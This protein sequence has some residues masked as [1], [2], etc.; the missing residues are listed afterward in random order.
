[1]KKKSIAVAVTAACIT[2]S[3]T[4]GGCS[5]VTKNNTAD[6]AQEIA[7]VD[8]RK[9]EKF[10]SS[11]LKDYEGAIA[12]SSVLKRDLLTAFLNVG[13]SYMNDNSDTSYADVFNMLVNSLVNNEILTQYAIM[14]CLEDKSTNTE[15]ILGYASDALSKFNA[16][17]DDLQGKYEYLLGGEN[18]DN[19]QIK[20]AKYRWYSS[21][22]SAIDN[23]EETADEEEGYKGTETRTTPV[24]LDT[25]Q[26]D[27]F[28]KDGDGNL[29]YNVYTGYKGYLLS[30]SG[31][32]K[33]DA[34]E[35]TNADS[36][37][38][39]YN[40]FLN[41]LRRNDFI[42]EKESQNLT[43]IKSL[44]YIKN[45]YVSQLESSIVNVFYDIY[46]EKQAAELSKN[47]YAY[48]NDIYEGLVDGQKD[49][50][51]TASAFES[52]MSSMSSTSFILSSPDTSDS[53]KLYGTEY[54]GKFGFVYNILLPFDS[55][56][57]VKLAELNSI[58][59]LDEDE[60]YYYAERN[61]LLRDI[62]T[63]DQ[64]GA[65]FNGQTDYSF[66]ASESGITEYYG[67]IKGYPAGV[68]NFDK[69]NTTGIQY[70]DDLEL[71]VEYEVRF[72]KEVLGLTVG[73][74]FTEVPKYAADY[75]INLIAE[76]SLIHTID[77]ETLALKHNY[78]IVNTPQTEYTISSRQVQVKLNYSSKEYVYGQ[79][80]E[81]PTFTLTVSKGQYED[82]LP[83]DFSTT[84]LPY[85]ETCD[86][87]VEYKGG[88]NITAEPR[89]VGKYHYEIVK[90][91][92][93]GSEKLTGNYWFSYQGPIITIVP[94]QIEI[95][96]DDMSAVYGDF[97]KGVP[98]T[99]TYTPTEGVLEYTDALT[100]NI[101]FFQTDE[102]GTIKFVTPKNADS[103]SIF[104]NSFTV[105]YFDGA[106]ETAAGDALKNYV[107]TCNNGTLE[108][109]KKQL[110]IAI[111]KD[112]SITY[113]ESAPDYNNIPYTLSSDGKVLTELPYGDKVNVAMHY[114]PS[115]PVNAGTYKI[116]Y[117][118]AADDYLQALTNY[119]VHGE[120]GLLTV[121]PKE[122]EATVKGGTAVYGYET[123]PEIVPVIT[124]GE[125]VGNEKLVPA[126]VFSLN[127]TVCDP[128]NVGT[129]DISVDETRCAVTGG[130]GL[131]GN[132][133]VT[134]IIDGNL[135]I[136]AS[137]LTVQI[138]GDSFTYGERDINVT[139]KVTA[140]KLYHNDNLELTYTYINKESGDRSENPTAA[141]S[142]A[143]TATATITGGN[144]SVDNYAITYV[145]DDPTLTITKR[146]I[147]ITL[148]QGGVTAFT[149]GT[150]YS[151][152]ICNAQIVGAVDGQTVTVAVT[153]RKKEE[154]GASAFSMLRARSF[155]ARAEAF[156]PKDAGTYIA[157]LDWDSCAVTDADGNAVDGGID[158]YELK[159]ACAD[160]EFVIAPMPLT[161]T[162]ENA[163]VTYGDKLPAALDYYVAENMPYG[164]SLALTFS[165][166]QENGKLPVH[167]GD[168]PVKVSGAAVNAG[169]IDN[170]VPE[171][172]NKNPRL[173]I[174]RRSLDI[175]LNS[176]TRSYGA[177]VS[178]KV[179][180]NNYVAD[181]SE[182]LVEGDV[183]TSTEVS[184]RGEDGTVYEGANLP[185]NVGTYAIVYVSSSITNAEGEDASADYKVNGIDGELKIDSSVITVYTAS[186]EETYNG[187]A[188][189][190]DKYD[191]YDGDLRGYKLVADADNICKQIDATTGDGVD[192]TTKFKIVDESGK[193]TQNLKLQYGEYGKLKVNRKKVDVTIKEATADYGVL[194]AIEHT[195]IG[196]VAE[197]MLSFSV[198]YAQGGEKVT[199]L[200]VGGFFILPVG[201]YVMNYVEDSA[202]ITGGQGKATN[203]ELV[204]A[205]DA[206]F[207]VTRRHIAVTTAGDGREYNGSP[208]SKTDGYT[209]EWVVDGVRQTDI[210]GLI[211]GDEL[212][213]A[214]TATQ[215]IVGSSS[216]ACTYTVSDNY[217]IDEELYEY[218]TLTVTQ[219]TVTAKTADVNVIYDGEPH[220]GGVVTDS[221][222]KLVAGHEF[223]VTSGLVAVVDVTAGVEN[224]LT[225]KIV[226]TNDGDRDV[227]ANYSVNYAYGKIIIRQRPLK[228]TTGGV[229]GVTYDGK[230]HGNNNYDAAEGLLTDEKYGHTLKVDTEF[231]Y[232][233]ATAGVENKTTYKVYCNG[234]DIS[235]NYAVDY[236][237]GSI[238]ID[239]K[240]VTVTLNGGVE[241][242]Y[243][244]GYAQLLTDGAV[245]LIDGE[246]IELAIK[247]DR[248]VDGVGVYTATADWQ[249][250][251]VRN[252]QGVIENGANNYAP[253]FS[254]ASVQFSVI[255]REIVVTLNAGC[256]TQFAYG[257]N[258]DTAIRTVTVSGMVGGETLNAAVTYNV[259]NPKYVGSYTAYIDEAKCTVNGG[260]I[261][262]YDIVACN[263]VNFEIVAKDITVYTDDINI[264]YGE[265]PAYPEGA[266]GYK[267]VEGLVGGDTLTV[268]PAFR[269][270]GEEVTSFVAG[271]YDIICGGITVNGG[272]VGAENYNFTTGTPY[273][274]LTVS[275]IGVEIVRK[276]VTKPYDGTPL[277]L[278]ANAPE[279]EVS[280]IING[281]SGEKLPAGYHIELVGTFATR[282][283]NVSS[284]CANT[285]EY[286]VVDEAT[287]EAAGNYVVTYANNGA[288]LEIVKKAIEITTDTPE[289]RA[290][291][292]QPLTAGYTF[293]ET[294]L[295]EGH[296]LSASNRASQKD[297]G[298]TANTMTFT[299]T[300]NGADVTANY[301]INATY[302][303]L[304][305]NKLAVSVEI[306]SVTKAYG[307]N[308]GV[309][310][311]NRKN[312]VNDEILYYRLQLEKD[313]EPCDTSKPLSAGTYEIV[314]KEGDASVSGG[315]ITNY[316]ISFSDGSTLKV[317][318]RQIIIYTANAEAEYSGQPLSR[319]DGYTTKWIK[320]DVEQNES[321]LINGD[322]LTVVTFASQTEVGSRKNECTYVLSD[323]AGNYEIAG[324]ECGTLTVTKIALK[325]TTNDINGVYKGSPYS[326]GGFTYDDKLLDGHTIAL[327]GSVR[328]F[329]DVIS[330]AKNEFKVAITA[331]GEDVTEKYYEIS[332]TYGD[333]NITKA[334]LTL[335]PND[336]HRT[337][338]YGFGNFDAQF[339][340]VAADNL[341]GND[342]LTTVALVYI[343]EDGSVLDGEPVN[344]GKYKVKVNLAGS[345]ISSADGVNRTD[346]YAV[347]CEEVTF[348]V[349]RRKITVSLNSWA[350]ETYNG[351]THTYAG[352]CEI[353]DGT[354]LGGETITS[355]V[356]AYYTDAEKN[357]SVAAPKDADTYYVFPDVSASKVRGANGEFA[358][359]QNYEVTCSHIEFT[360]NPK[361]L[362]I[363]LEDV[364][365]TYDG[366][367]YDYAGCGGMT[368]NLCD[369]DE[370]QCN[371]TYSGNHRDAGAYTVTFNENLVFTSG[372]A[373][374]YVLDK[375]NSKLTCELTISERT[376]IVWVDD[377]DV[378]KGSGEYTYAHITSSSAGDEG[379]VGNDLENAELTFRYFDESNTELEGM[380]ATVGTYTVTA[381]FG[382]DV[383]KNYVVQ[384]INAGTLKVTERKVRVT[385]VFNGTRPYYYDGNPVDGG[386]FGFVH[387]HSPEGAPTEEAGF[388][389]DD[390][391]NI[392]AVYTFTDLSNGREYIGTTPANAGM[393]RIS[394]KLTTLSGGDIEGYEITYR[395][396]YFTIEKRPLSYTVKVTGA[397]EY[398]YS[399]SRP[400]FSAELADGYD[401]FINDN[402]LPEHTFE[403]FAGDKPVTRYNV[404]TYQVRMAFEGME[405]YAIA[406]TTATVKIVP[407][408][409]VITPV[410]PYNG[411]AQPYNGTGLRLGANDREIVSKVNENG[412]LAAGDELTIRSTVFNPGAYT[413]KGRLEIAEVFIT[414]G[415]ADVSG[416]YKYYYQYDATNEAIKS[417]NLLAKDFR[418]D[419][420]YQQSVIH[421]EFGDLGQ[422]VYPY[423]GAAVPKHLDADTVKLADGNS[424]KFG[425]VLGL[426]KYDV[427]VPAAA[428]DYPD[429]I[430]DLV[431]V[432]DASGNNVSAIYILTCDNPEAGEIKVTRNVLDVQ[433][434]GMTADSL[435]AG[436]L[437][438]EVSGLFTGTTPAHQAEVYAFNLD[439]S[440][441]VGVT[442][443]SESDAGK[444]TD[445][446][447]NYELDGNCKL[448]G[449]TVRI[450]TLDEEEL[451]KRPSIGVEITVTES[452]LAGGKGT[453]YEFDGESRW[454]LK[455]G[456]TV[457]GVD[458]LEKNGHKLQV[459]VFREGGKYLLGV[460]VYSET[461]G[462]RSDARS[463]YRL[464]DLIT[465][466]V[467]ARYIAS[468][469]AANMQ[470]EIY[471]DFSE[472]FN[473]D[474]T[475]KTENGLLTGYS[476]KGLSDGHKIEVTVTEKDGKYEIG[477]AIFTVNASGRKLNKNTVYELKAVVP[478][479]VTAGII[480]GNL[481]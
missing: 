234:N 95:T 108:I 230:P 112:V 65:W 81:K 171:Y 78:N 201:N 461:N 411:V 281:D 468:S 56:Q 110:T 267:R 122:I 310:S 354:L 398:V 235:A 270:N 308:Y 408:T 97:E 465:S 186:L 339:K 70:S 241:V 272:A 164:E 144:A 374:N 329:T 268:I 31:A 117:E 38:K 167:V 115:Q 248:A 314:C 344:A 351:K 49:V 57:S 155:A 434:N 85:G 217:V 295:I 64:R 363:E 87:D 394:V 397:G 224:K 19:N 67:N 382:G 113:G 256:K 146:G 349:A 473:A 396:G 302:G 306:E 445:L 412:D 195:A 209:T 68:G 300:A 17:G 475:P 34:K 145:D 197:E 198:D 172:T 96:L 299:I 23:Y 105:T 378:E 246:T 228:I 174:T 200:T 469:E 423:T 136:T 208:L 181:A 303:T 446:S 326:D 54:S 190:T 135:E 478:D 205:P 279:S 193:E 315:N 83:A 247:V 422:T 350:D 448:D 18:N 242:Q 334:A 366:A 6:L 376:I 226:D 454:I 416:N 401:G 323:N 287:G 192:N 121:K 269:K 69:A 365:H 227:T 111:S 88:L 119:D 10:A 298:S 180:A 128:V 347:T 285:A 447:A 442:V 324:Y 379:F 51:T 278:N 72:A 477:V 387:V 221:L 427:N 368:T 202:Q 410:D 166:E 444:R 8:I 220:S 157:S 355:F 225:V 318:P 463:T 357:N 415:G 46:E 392:K 390:L 35:G 219:R 311:I 185:E 458:A 273:G 420:S 342:S 203:Y 48:I 451:Y 380:P 346:N 236:K 215:T 294:Q 317:T 340:P 62:R 20:L 464:K 240:A 253:E 98:A 367:V 290:Y 91:Y 79:K 127:G 320:D 150:P 466:G 280:Y 162:V 304:T 332:Y 471:I 288:R 159:A 163:A 58:K 55:K 116:V 371:I 66:K 147:E 2:L 92:V 435:T 107:I 407:R 139:F 133:K 364:S 282:D 137:P 424:L 149:Y 297:V 243:G 106:E 441:L 199:P 125:M 120:D 90:S 21:L 286:R 265:T 28:P 216:N 36:R 101:G 381:A 37:K 276:T 222:F 43:D 438:L 307:E 385:P 1:M 292:G 418:V 421:Y 480:D 370:I 187:A 369:G 33:D 419:V 32:Y 470:R 252:A 153:Y 212:T 75:Y 377:R 103:Y 258:Y 71:A 41:Y 312:L 84:E 39:A 77:G 102:E 24:N 356:V 455:G 9:S 15:S 260:N 244:N 254:P 168:Y 440:W 277:A 414:S 251:V 22:N 425:H 352:N 393:Y 322:T 143:I 76:N 319:T 233:Q 261:A 211:N 373:A 336:P 337:F 7:T 25:E 453:L 391:N 170:Y 289:A 327:S 165:F 321:G 328:Q 335:T 156:I 5:L 12:E 194:P 86:F 74:K 413:V 184:C 333:V 331:N 114:D 343:A 417:L 296:V 275:G 204:F 223:R 402:A 330:G 456:Y 358:I 443:F 481:N 383:M 109:A 177:D 404:G 191:G 386:L 403:L 140:G 126:Y 429:L 437:G 399:N 44:E 409:I 26:D 452:E 426:S 131:Y 239:K 459:L 178:Y 73:E 400:A 189:F 353:T 45:Q 13:A 479:G 179:E 94:K 431:K 4:L 291:N 158:N 130:N 439:G 196:L 348:T 476:Y 151:G 53:D 63:E 361:D 360:I 274:T 338:D 474:G 148:N 183:L 325:V 132:Y 104:A 255:P 176:Y 30:D 345:V 232:S 99:Y 462:R 430:R 395:N 124:A 250:S 40:R 406:A 432:Y 264:G 61:K 238:V 450:I 152:D 433:F 384:R 141:G 245:T 50:Y 60:D 27:Y 213:V 472:A 188:H 169:K 134:Y 316:D 259:T 175:Q 16:Y 237:Y 29:D 428:G 405:N 42:T 359:G 100:V 80:I 460:T 362:V 3:A 82:E 47:G 173:T 257:A 266:S 218:G 93:N 389:G 283:G 467:A 309:G 301:Q 313:G 436:K 123:L 160:V 52:A 375:T 182:V 142:Y 138:T 271:T 210:S 449:A 14:Y 206:A 388:D 341:V 249:N 262:N 89:N 207:E 284:S 457:S 214:T 263:D 372:N 305:V 59:T 11:G 129:Y 231:T 161:V 154:S 118:G 229:S 293:D